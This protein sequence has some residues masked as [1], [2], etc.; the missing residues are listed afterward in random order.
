MKVGEL[1]IEGRLRL[2]RE[3]AR[4]L[5]ERPVDRNPTGGDDLIEQVELDLFRRNSGMR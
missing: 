2:Q 4:R 3:G 5:S 1:C